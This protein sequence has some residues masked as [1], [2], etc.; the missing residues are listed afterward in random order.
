MIIL[1][2]AI[3]L[4]LTIV[5]PHVNSNSELTGFF[6]FCF[7]ISVI[8]GVILGACIINGRTINPKIEMYSEENQNIENEI[9]TLVEKYMNY[10]SDTY[11]ELKGESGITLVS[12]YPEL[13]AD[14]LL[15]KQIELYM[16]NNQKIKSLKEKL[17][18]L[19]NLKW[20]LYFGN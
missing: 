13:K 7:G 5:W 15:E 8:V 18:N 14:T 4:I 1:L 16:E 11:G 3:F 9:N 20:W 10:E 17:I 19:T 2:I 12:L 6:E